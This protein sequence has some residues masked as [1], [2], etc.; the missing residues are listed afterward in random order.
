[1]YVIKTPSVAVPDLNPDACPTLSHVAHSG[2]VLLSYGV[3]NIEN[4]QKKTSL[5]SHLFLWI[6]NANKVAY[7][8]KI[9]CEN[10]LRILKM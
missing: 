4:D 9:A 10:G 1:M 6:C 2:Q 3:N 8:M 5:L 7:D